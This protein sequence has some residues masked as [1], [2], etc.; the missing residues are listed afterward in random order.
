MFLWGPLC[1]PRPDATVQSVKALMSVMQRKR[2]ILKASVV[3]WKALW[4]EEGYGIHCE[5]EDGE[6][7]GV[8]I[9]TLE[10]AEDAAQEAVERGEAFIEG[11]Q[12]KMGVDPDEPGLVITRH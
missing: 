3:D 11:L 9:G 6:N 2:Q 10:A 1:Q 5:Y 7:F 8:F 4:D 12:E